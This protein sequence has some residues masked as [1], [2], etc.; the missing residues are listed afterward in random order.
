MTQPLTVQGQEVARGVAASS[1]SS[2]GRQ[3]SPGP[4]RRSPESITSMAIAPIQRGDITRSYDLSRSRTGILVQ[5]ARSMANEMKPEV[6]L[7]GAFNMLVFLT[8][9]GLIFQET[10]DESVHHDDAAHALED[11]TANLGNVEKVIT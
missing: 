10:H 1:G 3:P 5:Q 6:A 8:G 11:C 2:V 4:E 9:L 7:R